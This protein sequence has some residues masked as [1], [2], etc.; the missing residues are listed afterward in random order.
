MRQTAGAERGEGSLRQ[1]TIAANGLEFAYLE[2]GTGPLALCLHGFPDSPWT[3]RHLLPALAGAGYHAVA[4]FLRGYAPTGIPA[5]GGYRAADLVADALALHEALGGGG[6][7][8]LIGHDW[9]AATAYGAAPAAPERWRRVVVLDIPPASIYARIAFRYEQIKRTFYF[10][11]FQ[12]AVAEEAVAAD[13]LRFIEGLWADWSPGHDAAED[14]VYAK[15]CIRD[16]AHLRAALG[17]YRAFFDPAYFGSPA[18]AAD[19]EAVWGR[20]VPQPALYLHGRNDGCMAL[21]EETMRAVP[22][23]IGP[24]AEAEWVEGAGHFL[25]VERPA[26]VNAR[27]LSFLER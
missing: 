25:L 16:P 8:V 1:G 19:A 6:D 2:A 23:A 9:G 4:P 17:Y 21:D 13:D 12:M 15:A 11:F 27:I 7:A 26:H 20:P 22:A 5:D 10:W 14:V 18:A 24:L 3:Y